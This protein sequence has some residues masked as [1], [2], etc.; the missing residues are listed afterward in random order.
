LERVHFWK[1]YRARVSDTLIDA[2]LK[3]GK[4][5]SRNGQNCS[6]KSLWCKPSTHLNEVMRFSRFG[7]VAS[8]NLNTL[9]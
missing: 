9:H 8:I 3:N 7:R 4:K 6:L 5:T 1:P 2:S